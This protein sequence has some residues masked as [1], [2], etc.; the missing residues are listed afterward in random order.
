MRLLFLVLISLFT[1]PAFAGILRCEA[2]NGS[3]TEVGFD[4]DLQVEYAMMQIGLTDIELIRNASIDILEVTPDGHALKVD[5]FILQDA[6]EEI[7]LIV[8]GNVYMDK[9]GIY[10]VTSCQYK[11]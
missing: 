3:W 9:S 1:A 10:T 2:D 4:E 7:V 11:E 6:A 8:D 5:F